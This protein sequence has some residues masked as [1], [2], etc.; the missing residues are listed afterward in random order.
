[1][2]YLIV[3]NQTLGSAE[4]AATVRL[5]ADEGA[6]HFHIVVPAAAG[7]DHTLFAEDAREMAEQRLRAAIERFGRL[8]PTVSGEVGGADPVE[9][10]RG[11]LEKERFD[12]IIL[13]TLPPA[14]SH[15]LRRDVAGRLRRRFPSVLIEHVPTAVDTVVVDSGGTPPPEVSRSPSRT[16]FDRLVSRGQRAI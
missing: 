13:G 7:Q 3:A 5:R 2:R 11:A 14:R 10:A 8:G 15:W 1:M 4:L 9:A 16:E 12:S 6:E